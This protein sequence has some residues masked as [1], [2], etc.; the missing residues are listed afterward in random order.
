MSIVGTATD[1]HTFNVEISDARSTNA[2]EH[3]GDALA[4]QGGGASQRRVTAGAT[5]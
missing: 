1:I 4:E 2:S 5:R 3:R